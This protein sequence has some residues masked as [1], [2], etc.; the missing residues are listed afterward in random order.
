MAEALAT[1]LSGG[2]LRGFSAGSHPKGTVH[3][4]AL[5]TLQT[6]DIPASGLR[7]KR[8]DEFANAGAP[9]MDVV[10]T[11][12]DNAAREVCPVWPGHPA[13]A[14]WGI[15]DP[16]GVDG[17]EDVKQKAFEC[18]YQELETRILAMLALPVESLND[19]QLARELQRIGKE[20]AQPRP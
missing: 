7:S 8:W 3:P 10:L 16:A 5:K 9:R 14:H 11:V 17:T 1:H 20:P 2:R 15:E 18:A 12:C 19:Q 4:L 6:H 13:T